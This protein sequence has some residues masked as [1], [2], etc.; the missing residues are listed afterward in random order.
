MRSQATALREGDDRAARLREAASVRA[1]VSEPHLLAARIAAKEGGGGRLALER[2]DAPSLEVVLAARGRL[3]PRAAVAVVAGAARAVV[4]LERAGLAA[5]DI[6]PLTI[7]L[8]SKRGA[9]LADFG[10]PLELAPLERADSDPHLFFRA[11]EER[12]GGNRSPLGS[13]YSLGAI[14]LATVTGEAPPERLAAAQERRGREVPPTLES[15]IAR[16]MT[17]DPARRYADATEMATAAVQA[18]RTSERLGRA[19]EEARQ[20]QEAVRPKQAKPGRVIRWRRPARAPD[21]EATAQRETMVHE[22]AEAARKAREAEEHEAAEAARKALEAQERRAVE[23]ARRAQEA[24]ERDAAERDRKAVEAAEREQRAAERAEA[25][26]VQRERLRAVRAQR[27]AAKRAGR[28]RQAEQAASRRAAQAAKR[29]RAR[30][31]ARRPTRDERVGHRTATPAHA[32]MPKTVPERRGR[33]HRAAPQRK[34][35]TLAAAAKGA[36]ARKATAAAAIAAV[37]AGAAAALIASTG[38]GSDEVASVRVQSG[39]LSVRLPAGWS[40]T[41]SRGLR[42]GPLS[43]RMHAAA[44]GRE[45]TLT[46]AL[47]REPAR[48]AARLRGLEA[49]AAAR[50]AAKRL[51]RVETLRFAGISTRPGWTGNAYVLNTTGASVLVVCQARGEAPAQA[52][53]DCGAAAATARLA[54]HAPLTLQAAAERRHAVRRALAELGAARITDRDRIAAAETGEELTDA[55]LDLKARYHETSRRIQGIGLPGI[56]ARRL[57]AALA[58]TGR[59]YGAI[60]DAVIDG[61]EVAYDTARRRVLVGEARLGKLMTPGMAELLADQR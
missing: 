54:G 44:P 35:A 50:P 18:L 59:A 47:M 22:A 58:R 17:A 41:H 42:L 53:H 12:G 52:L 43:D 60:A 38:G 25:E 48:T 11:P 4:A 21:D 23:A 10:I 5:R 36:R 9:V 49:P 6:T 15:V 14:L 57:V 34:P 3:G 27:K 55:S 45:A 37:A 40:E 24:A 61:D 32:K 28:R 13:V 8:D 56:A 39:D 51:G 46:A 31:A 7:L 33:T 20:K 26:R 19:R 2:L 1:S 30:A 16:A 29:K